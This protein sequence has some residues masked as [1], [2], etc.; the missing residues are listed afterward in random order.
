VRLASTELQEL[1][2][3]TRS[4]VPAHDA[5]QARQLVNSW[6]LYEKLDRHGVVEDHVSRDEHAARTY[7]DRERVERACRVLDDDGQADGCS[8]L[9][10]AGFPFGWA[11]WI[12]KG[13]SRLDQGRSLVVLGAPKY[14]RCR[15]LFGARK[16]HMPLR[17][18]PRHAAAP[19]PAR[20]RPLVDSHG[21]ECQTDSRGGSG[22]AEPSI[23]AEAST[24][25]VL[26]IDD[27]FDVRRTHVKML[28]RGG[29]EVEPSPSAT[30]ALQAIERGLRASVIVTDLNMPRL[31]GIDFLRAVRRFDQDVP[32]VIVTGFPSLETAIEAIHYGGFRYLTKPVPA[33]ELVAA[34]RDGAAMHRLAVL[35][36]RALELY[37]DSRF[38]FADRAAL[39]GAFERALEQLWVAFQ[40]IVNWRKREIVGYEALMRSHEPLLADPDALLGAAERLGRLRELGRRMRNHVVHAVQVAPIE[41]LLFTNLHSAD[42]N[43]DDLYKAASP[44]GACAD[45]IVLEITERSSLDRVPDLKD[46][47][48]SLRDLGFKIAVD[49]LG[50]GYAGLSSFSQLEP[51][52][53]K[54]DTSLIRD[55]DISPQKKSIVRSLLD[56]CRDDLGVQVICE[57]VETPAERDTLDE[58]GSVTLQGYLFGRPAVGFT[59][60]RWTASPPAS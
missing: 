35:K 24:G 13:A 41:T 36:R 56:V 46:R 25:P 11:V 40:P 1:H 28:E 27:D 21:R 10:S 19:R 47:V 22:S 30:H 7:I 48:K 54:L 57:G 49:D 45:H 20:R 15:K 31:T 39:E 44:L 59:E 8:G 33:A 9:R 58:L 60:P 37:G 12:G 34:V 53:A 43:D 18:G 29:F 16:T 50:A 55:I 5:G 38:H 51:D 2:A 3:E 14:G 23:M 6:K 32:V 17:H 42:L 52:I 26:L 4:V